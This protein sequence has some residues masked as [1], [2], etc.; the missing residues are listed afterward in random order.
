MIN[1]WYSLIFLIMRAFY[2]SL[3]AAWINDESIKPIRILRS[4][5]SNAWNAESKRFFDEVVNG[6]IALSGMKFYF[7]TRKLI[8]SVSNTSIIY[9]KSKCLRINF[10]YFN[11]HFRLQVR[12]LSYHELFRYI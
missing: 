2:V 1:F 6:T 9:K 3:T 5:S 8:L 7:L 4:V 12:K 11:F 10:G